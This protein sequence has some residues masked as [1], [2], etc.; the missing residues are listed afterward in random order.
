MHDETNDSYAH[1]LLPDFPRFETPLSIKGD[2]STFPRGLA[3]DYGNSVEIAPQNP[4]D[5]PIPP[6]PIL[7]CLTTDGILLAYHC[8]DWSHS[9]SSSNMIK[10]QRL[11]PTSIIPRTLVDGEA[12]RGIRSTS[13]PHVVAQSEPG[14]GPFGDIISHLKDAIEEVRYLLPR[15]IPSQL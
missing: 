13:P 2:K 1:G 12:D 11:S 5:P 15:S 10:R 7:W 3:I 6:K 9:K 14:G 8:V 4:D